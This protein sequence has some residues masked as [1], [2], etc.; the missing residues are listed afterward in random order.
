VAEPS[1]DARSGEPRSLTALLLVLLASPLALLFHSGTGTSAADKH[2]AA[3]ERATAKQAQ[4]PVP[5]G[6]CVD[7]FLEE[8]TGEPRDDTAPD[9]TLTARGRLDRATGDVKLRVTSKD[10]PQP[11]WLERLRVAQLGL[12]NARACLAIDTLIATVPDPLDSGM[13]YLFDA[14]LQ[15]LRLGIEQPLTEVAS[16]ERPI[17]SYYQERMWLPWDDGQAGD[18]K[19]ENTERC[20]DT[21]PGLLVFRGSDVARPRVFAVLL[22]G[23]TPTGG[24]HA[25]AMS[26]A[27]AAASILTT[28]TRSQACQRDGDDDCA[29]YPERP[30]CP[31]TACAKIVGPTYSGSATSMRTAIDQWARNEP[32][33]SVRIVTGSANGDMLVPT[34]RSLS[35]QNGSVTGAVEFASTIPSAETQECGYYWFLKERLGIDTER[36]VLPGDN[37]LV[38]QGVALLHE[39]GTQFG[40]TTTTHCDLKPEVDVSFPIHIA[41]LRSAYDSVDQKNEDPS[42]P[43]TRP[44]SLNVSLKQQRRPVDLPSPLSPTTTNAQ[45]LTLQNVLLA[46][47][48]ERVRHIAIQSTDIGDAIFLAR[49]MRDVVPDVRLAF[50]E[51]D[52]LLLHDTFRR[53]VVGSFVVSAYPFLGTDSFVQ[54]SGEYRHLGLQSAYAEGQ[55][56][57]VLAARG[58]PLDALHEYT[59]TGSIHSTTLPLWISAIGY[60]GLTPV[61]VRTSLDCDHAIFG[62]SLGRPLSPDEADACD[63]HTVGQDPRK[64]DL[65]RAKLDT[66]SRETVDIDD[67]LTP[68]RIWHLAYWGLVVCFLVDARRRRQAARRLSKALMPEKLGS[69]TDVQADLAIGRTK[70]ELYAAIRVIV[71]LFSLFAMGLLYGLVLWTFWRQHAE[72]VAWERVTG[73]RIWIVVSLGGAAIVLLYCGVEAVRAIGV[74]GRDFKDFKRAT[75][76]GCSGTLPAHL[77]WID[78]WVLLPFG[79]LRPDGRVESACTSFAQVRFVLWAC[80]VG[81]LLFIVGMPFELLFLA[82][83]RFAA[84]GGGPAHTLLVLREVSLMSGMSPIL[85]ILLF[86]VCVYGWA[87][88]RT[89]RLLLV[90]RLARLTPKGCAADLVSTPIEMLL[91]PKAPDATKAGTSSESEGGYASMERDLVN[92]ILRPST[93]PQYALALVATASFPFVAFLTK[94]PSTLETCLG[95]FLLM[96]GVSLCT[97]LVVATL[98][99]LFQYWIALQKLLKRSMEHPLGDAFRR[100]EPFAQDSLEQ[101]VSRTPD[102]LLRLT[103]CAERFGLLAAASE[104]FGSG[105]FFDALAGLRTEAAKLSEKSRL[106]LSQSNSRD[107]AVRAQN[108]EELGQALVLAGRSLSLLLCSSRTGAL[109]TG[110]EQLAVPVAPGPAGTPTRADSEDAAVP[111]DAAWAVEWRFTPRE[112][113]WLRRA[114]GLVATIVVLLV[115]RHIRQFRAFVYTLTACTLVLLAAISSYPFEPHRLLFTFAWA[116]ICGVVVAGLWIYIELDQ[117]TFMSQVAGTTPGHLTLNFALAGRVVTWVVLPLLGVAATQYPALANTL[118][119]V[120]EPFAHA[121]R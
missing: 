86:G 91:Y 29:T 66:V 40:A 59:L 105:A 18:A 100:I 65:A 82:T 101:Q 22:V 28:G 104:S 114:Q 4:N 63:T 75:R 16:A 27:L 71:F 35:S 9:P 24:V 33:V 31:C 121:L 117:N 11:P 106:S 99:Q 64:R 112:M 74:F 45:D 5:P 53:D 8:L 67:D 50:F 20:R 90:H 13:P 43:L 38:L 60:G 73:A 46:V 70:I 108:E 111:G 102:D 77:K 97:C 19:R 81:A 1:T 32:G 95:T 68:P 107:L 25:A 120:V 61:A 76:N 42:S 103:A 47:S 116:L 56:N 39:S 34:F 2:A 12:R 15:A 84:G 58:F 57:A 89:K 23:E 6:Q 87:V 78:R 62:P 14:S 96:A 3:E 92:S 41:T 55:L 115:N 21:M 94:P 44:T 88:G 10:E 83:G 7:R 93:G 49:K 30:L 118:F 72:V 36:S 52:A 54:P 119:R 51:A 37:R 113:A 98:I 85:P 79:F 80:A 48:R 69:E 109:K 26:N 110:G 17:L